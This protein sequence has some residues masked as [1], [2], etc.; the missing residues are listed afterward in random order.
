MPWFSHCSSLSI[1][2]QGDPSRLC[3]LIQETMGKQH[4]S[5]SRNNL[6]GQL[7]V[8]VEKADFKDTAK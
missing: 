5:T 7:E 2:Q 1:K 3:V 8:W 4:K 6:K